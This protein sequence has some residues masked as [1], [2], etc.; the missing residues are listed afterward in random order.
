MNYYEQH[1][2]DFARDAGYLTMIREG[3][4]RRMIDAYYAT[5]KPL[6]ANPD[7]LYDLTRCTSKAE[8]DAV[9]YCLLKFFKLAP[10]GWHQ[11]RCDEEIER[12]RLSE[13]EREA[14]REND[15]ERQRRHRERRAQLFNELRARGQVPAFDT[16][17]AA[18]EGMLSRVT[19][20]NG[21][22][23]ATAP[24]TPVTCDATATIPQ[25]PFPSPHSHSHIKTSE[26]PQPPLEKGAVR[27]TRSERKTRQQEALHRWNRLINSGGAD[28]EGLGS[29]ISAV[30]GWPAIRMRT[31]SDEARMRK[32]FCDAYAGAQS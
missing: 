17:T 5:E 4:Y 13:P 28:R 29:A 18:L 6:P 21:H 25:S 11:K 14:K 2:G 7:D 10:D 8:R 20:G 26:N 1:L 9:D 30:G 32:A 19:N 15:K 23:T 3:A 27:E 16:T 31:E 24:V 12:Y 22:G